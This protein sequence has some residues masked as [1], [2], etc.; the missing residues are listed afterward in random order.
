[1]R[2]E[3]VR[4][5]RRELLRYSPSKRREVIRK[6]N[7]QIITMV[8]SVVG[9]LIAV[10]CSDRNPMHTWATYEYPEYGFA[11]E[12]PNEPIESST[13][14]RTQDGLVPVRQFQHKSI[15][16]VYYVSVA[17]FP[18]K[19]IQSQPKKRTL[20]IMMEDQILGM[21]GALLESS[22][23]SF[24]GYPA[25]FFSA[26]LPKDGVELRNDNTLTSII[27]I[28]GNRIYRAS[29]IGL[30]NEGERTRFLGSFTLL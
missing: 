10:G 8:A 23:R 28:K 2:R 27:V 25:I 5:E 13:Q 1:M 15:A 12:M 21:N 6:A 30:G 24:D 19:L 7:I 16:F 26:Q 17:E 29:A 11:V 22:H 9:F 18:S 3:R 4:R 14:L 20:D